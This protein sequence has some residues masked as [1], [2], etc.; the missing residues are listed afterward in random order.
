MGVNINIK[1]GVGYCSCLQES[2]MLL[3]F[4]QLLP[5]KVI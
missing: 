2:P 5:V 3:L 4:N 1:N